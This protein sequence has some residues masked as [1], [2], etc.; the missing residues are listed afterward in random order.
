MRTSSPRPAGTTW[1]S[2]GGSPGRL[3]FQVEAEA[4]RVELGMGGAGGCAAW[5]DRTGRYGAAFLTRGLGGHDRGEVVWQAV[6][7]T[8]SPPAG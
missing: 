6:T 7:D 8:F 3:G 2:T 1:S 4:G 5:A